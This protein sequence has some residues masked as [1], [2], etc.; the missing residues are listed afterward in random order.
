MCDDVRQEVGDRYSIMGV[1]QI[2]AIRDFTKP[3]P[4]FTVLAHWIFPDA[5]TYKI[6]TNITSPSG[7]TIVNVSRD[8]NLT[9]PKNKPDGYHVVD[10]SKFGNVV[11]PE[12]GTYVIRL[13]CDGIERYASNLFIVKWSA[14]TQP[15]TLTTMPSNVT[16][17]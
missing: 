6:G 5:G 3:V 11:F 2:A 12:T 14:P 16:K 1:W 10:M 15:Q 8:Y 7:K 4:P 13:T 17:H 9:G